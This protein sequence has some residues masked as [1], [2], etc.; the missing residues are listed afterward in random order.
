MLEQDT[1]YTVDAID[2]MRKR[3]DPAIPAEVPKANWSL[4]VSVTIVMAAPSV[5]PIKNTPNETSTDARTLVPTPHVAMEPK[6][7][8]PR[9]MPTT[10]CHLRYPIFF[11]EK[12]KIHTC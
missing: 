2:E 1:T 3:I 12:P 11:P 4:A 8:A 10:H 9:M 6:Q 7:I 5:H